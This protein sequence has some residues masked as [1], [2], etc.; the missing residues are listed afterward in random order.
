MP[1]DEGE[2]RALCSIV[3]EVFPWWTPKSTLAPIDVEKVGALSSL[4]T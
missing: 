2:D 3:L 4:V 1:Q